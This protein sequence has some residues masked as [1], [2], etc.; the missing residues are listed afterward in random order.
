M[1]GKVL[2]GLYIIAV[3]L[4]FPYSL[5]RTKEKGYDY[6]LYY[7]A[8]C[9]DITDDEALGAYMYSYKTIG[10][11][12]PFARLGYDAGFALF[13]EILAAAGLYLLW[14]VWRDFQELEF[15]RNA[16]LFVVTAALFLNLRCGNIT[17]LLAAL[18]YTPLGCVAA[19]CLKPHLGVFLLLHAA[20]YSTLH[21]EGEAVLLHRQAEQSCVP[22]GNLGR[23][24]GKG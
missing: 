11:F 19:A 13:Y 18:C 7:R 4:W 6:H 15:V 3:S 9:G 5:E 8:A 1:A 21:R 22:S 23:T 10:I 12:K 20:R 17:P 14:R 24:G 2:V 16:A